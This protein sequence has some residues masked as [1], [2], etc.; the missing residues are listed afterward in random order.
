[1]LDYSVH[2]AASEHILHLAANMRTADRREVWAAHR[3]TPF[4]ALALSLD[5]S[6]RAWTA[7]IDGQPALMWGVARERGLIHRAQGI[8]WLLAT[9]ELERQAAREFIRQSRDYVRRMQA[10]FRRL[11]NY[12]HAANKVSIRWLKWCGF[13]LADQPVKINDEDFY[14]FWRDA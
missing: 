7:F 8:P 4:E 9:D 13:R 6:E 1:M 10:G 11:E 3:Q 14:Y 12:V 5:S 2:P